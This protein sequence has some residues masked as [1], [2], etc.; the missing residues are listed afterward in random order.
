MNEELRQNLRYAAIQAF[1][2]TECRGMA[3]VDFL[4]KPDGTF[5]LN[6]LNTLPGFTNISMYPRLWEASGLMY[7]ELLHKLIDLAFE[8]K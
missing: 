1:L 2:A 7:P 6:E 8:A 4:V 5:F 3:R